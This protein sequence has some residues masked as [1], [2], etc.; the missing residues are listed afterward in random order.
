MPF[1]RSCNIIFDKPVYGYDYNLYNMAGQL[2]SEA[3]TRLQNSN[4]IT[5]DMTGMAAGVYF[6]HLKDCCEEQAV[7][8]LLKN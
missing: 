4:I 2:V 3:R 8:K 5:V 7:I 6:M 1:E